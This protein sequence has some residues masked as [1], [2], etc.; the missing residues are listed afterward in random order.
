M[1]TS[2][3]P[4][5][6]R[7]HILGVRHAFLPHVGNGTRWCGMIAFKTKLALL[8]STKATLHEIDF[9]MYAGFRSLSIYF[10]S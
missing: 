8:V 4:P 9:Y 1:F 3:P 10:V 6:P 5:P 2:S 7:R